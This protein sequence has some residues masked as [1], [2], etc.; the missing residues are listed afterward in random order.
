M[1][2]AFN[3]FLA[4][5]LTILVLSTAAFAQ[6]G[7]SSLG[8][9]AIGTKEVDPS[10]AKIA[11][12]IK[13]AIDNARPDGS[14]ENSPG[15]IIYPDGSSMSDVMQTGEWE[16]NIPN[17]GNVA[18]VS[19]KPAIR[20]CRVDLKDHKAY[21]FEIVYV[22]AVCSDLT[23]RYRRLSVSFKRIGPCKQNEYE[24][25]RRKAQDTYGETWPETT[26]VVFEPNLPGKD[27]G[28][29]VTDEGGNTGGL[30]PNMVMLEEK[31]IVVIW[32]KDDTW[33][34]ATYYP[35]G[36]SAWSGKK[37]QS[38]YPLEKPRACRHQSLAEK[39][40][41]RLRPRR[42]SRR[43]RTK[44]RRHPGQAAR[45]NRHNSR[46]RARRARRLQRRPSAQGRLRNRMFPD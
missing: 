31:Y 35:D 34:E 22:E 10:E 37:D 44:P 25:A 9:D 2:T 46:R 17:C 11:E 1:K 20:E 29:Q 23:P 27:G 24:E 32:K 26:D 28:T 45:E 12:E 43:R 13:K 33:Y 40:R 39:S 3:G 42:Q 41:S 4:A 7:G 14:I 8:G 36:T 21:L 38:D 18:N 6:H 5:S 16:V 30:T 19:T 15:V